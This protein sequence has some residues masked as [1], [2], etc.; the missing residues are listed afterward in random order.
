MLNSKSRKRMKKILLCITSVCLMTSC[1]ESFLDTDNLTKKDS[2]IF[3]K[4]TADAN[5]VL[6]AMYRPIMGDA[7]SPQSSS[8]F[9][10]ELMSDDRFGAGGTDDHVPRHL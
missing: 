7:N 8:F 2:S 4:S 3:P 9:I 1:S 10:A 6:T 5:Q